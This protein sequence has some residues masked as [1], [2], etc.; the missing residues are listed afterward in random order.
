MWESYARKH[1]IPLAKNDD[2]DKGKFPPSRFL[3]DE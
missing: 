2:K 3:F 1:N